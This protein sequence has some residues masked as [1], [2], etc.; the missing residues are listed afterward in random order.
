MKLLIVEDDRNK[1][2][3]LRELIKSRFP[4]TDVDTRSSYH[5]GAKSALSGGYDLILLDMSMP[6]YEASSSSS[7]GSPLH[8]AGREVLRQMK[9]RDVVAQVIVVTQFDTFGEGASRMSLEE[10]TEALRRDHPGSFLGTIYYH[11]KQEQWKTELVRH[12]ET[13]TKRISR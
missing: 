11:P 8:F 3:Q 10:L 1:L 2:E 7:G 13:L 4:D 12:V 9:R 6:T 5:H